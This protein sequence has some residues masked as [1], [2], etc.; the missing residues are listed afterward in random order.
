[1]KHILLSIACFFG[2]LISINGQCNIIKLNNQLEVD[3]FDITDYSCWPELGNYVRIEVKG[4]DI[5]NLNGLNALDTISSLRIENTSLVNLEGLENLTWVYSSYAMLAAPGIEIADNELLENL[6]GLENLRK[7]SNFK[8]VDNPVLQN[9]NALNIT[10]VVK[11]D[12]DFYPHGGVVEIVNNPMLVGITGLSGLWFS[13]D[14]LIKD[15]Q[16]LTDISG[17]SNLRSVQHRT[18]GMEAMGSV[19]IDNNDALISLAIL[20]SLDVNRDFTISNNAML[21]NL[22]GISLI[23]KDLIIDNNANLDEF[24][25]FE[26]TL[27]FYLAWPALSNFQ[28]SNNPLLNSIGIS[29]FGDIYSDLNVIVDI[30]NNPLLSICNEDYICYLINEHEFTDFDANNN[31]VGCNLSD[32]DCEGPEITQAKDFEVTTERE[33]T[34]CSLLDYRITVTN[35]TSNLDSV[36]LKFHIGELGNSSLYQYVN[37]DQA[38]ILGDTLIWDVGNLDSLEMHVFNISFDVIGDYS[39]IAVLDAVAFILDH[40]NSNSNVAAAVGYNFIEDDLLLQSQAD[41]DSCYCIN[42]IYGQLLIKDGLDISNLDGLTNLIVAEGGVIIEGNP[43]LESIPGLSELQTPINKVAIIN[44][45][46]LKD[47]TGFNNFFLLDSLEIIGNDS[48]MDFTG[49]KNSTIAEIHIENNSILESLNFQNLKVN[50]L[51]VKNNLELSSLDSLYSVTGL[52]G[53]LHIEGNAELLSLNGLH[54]LSTIGGSS[55]FYDD[56]GITIMDNAGLSNLNDFA[57]LLTLQGN[58]KFTNNESLVSLEYF[59]PTLLDSSIVVIENNPSLSTCGTDFVCNVL[60]DEQV[61]TSISNNSGGC[62]SIEEVTTACTTNISNILQDDLFDIHPNPVQDQLS[63]QYKGLQANRFDIQLQS[64]EGNVLYEA[65][66]IIL[67]NKSIDVQHLH[68]G[69]YLLSL[70]SDEGYFVKKLVVE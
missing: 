33:F 68:S 23:A 21:E 56:V 54:N 34:N 6:K 10:S 29:G 51:V 20:D 30:E 15:N 14:I 5:T 67:N 64:I 69:I 32:L 35:K 12:S 60:L 49:F 63:I 11:Y 19:I 61:D 41:V 3:T 46:N 25:D 52:I 26:F 53:G 39:D 42:A 45:D 44:N 7:I 59:N 37:V 36:K 17:L 27:R 8:L 57:N 18:G 24:G 4:Q 50:K 65:S 2:A 31:A 70:K 38:T 22:S 13:S 58:V 48:L 28:V 1:M 62:N 66:D 16:S 40:D 43:I 47:L 55:E 9:T